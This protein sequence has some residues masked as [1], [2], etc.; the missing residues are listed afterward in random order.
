MQ[1]SLADSSPPSSSRWLTFC[2]CI[3]GSAHLE[4][5]LPCQDAGRLAVLGEHG[6]TVLLALSD[7]AGSAAYAERG[8]QIVVQQWMEHFQTLLQDHPDPAGVLTDCDA[9]DIGLI[10]R[11][12]REAV[13]SEAS[14]LGVEPVEFSATLLGAVVTGTQ[15]LVAQVGDGA[16]VGLFNGICGCLTWPVNGEFAGQT[17][18]ANSEA[19]ADSLQLVH[20]Q[21][22]PSALAGFTD[23]L[24]RVL[25]DFQ[26]RQP[27][28][29]FFLPV[30][31]AL[32]HDT[33]HFST[34][35]E[36]YLQS[37]SV[38]ARTDDDK[39]LAILLNL[40]EEL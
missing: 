36:Q 18:F 8:A 2:A 31:R 5:G 1:A 7:G 30:F 13:A 39:S 6:D 26:T 33:Q 34:Q 27:A 28:S 40:T 38:C 22:A 24:E 12:I 29:G 21:K 19:A 4:N 16:W 20:L 9:T 32:K 3:K 11:R 14:V 15:A 25:L 35:L 23:G 10:L 37:E 17:T